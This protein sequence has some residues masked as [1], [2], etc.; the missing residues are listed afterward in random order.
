LTA[1]RLV[2]YRTAPG[3]IV[4]SWDE[5]L[6]VAYA[7]S[8]AKTHL[9]SAAGAAILDAAS[10]ARVSPEMLLS[11]CLAEDDSAQASDEEVLQHLQLTLEGLVSA[12]L[13]SCQP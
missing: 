8:Q 2:L 13:L 7:P 10:V 9:V 3:L 5:D 1:R 11:M 4:K 12:G 6:A